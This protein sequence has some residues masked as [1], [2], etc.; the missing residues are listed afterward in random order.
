MKLHLSFSRL[1]ELKN[2][3]GAADSSW[4]LGQTRQWRRTQIKLQLQSGIEF[5]ELSK[6]EVGENGDVTV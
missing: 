2:K 3:I 6:I 4:R 5:S 1:A